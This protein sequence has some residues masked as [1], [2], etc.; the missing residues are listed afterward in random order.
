MNHYYS[1]ISHIEPSATRV[2]DLLVPGSHT[3][4]ANGFVCHNSGKDCTKVD[5]SAAYMARYIA[6]NIVAAGL[7][8]RCEIQLSYAI[9]SR[10]PISLFIDTFGTSKVEPQKICDLVKKHFDMTPSGIIKQLDL[11]KP[12][13]SKTA[14]YGHFGRNEPEFTWER[15]DKAGILR[16]EAGA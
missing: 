8:D 9:G 15:T 12:I 5:R 11:R 10:E 6:K 2:F 7:A 16:K 4:T 3:F 13:Y 14:C 1:R